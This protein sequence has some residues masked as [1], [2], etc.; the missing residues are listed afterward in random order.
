MASYDY[1]NYLEAGFSRDEIL[2][3]YAQAY[4]GATSL[5]DGARIVMT[6]SY[7]RALLLLLQWTMARFDAV[8]QRHRRASADTATPSSCGETP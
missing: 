1:A 2:L 6:P 8:Q 3:R 5:A 4:D 7:A